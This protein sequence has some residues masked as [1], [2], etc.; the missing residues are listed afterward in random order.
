MFYVNC[1]VNNAS[2]VFINGCSFVRFKTI[3]LLSGA[4][5]TVEKEREGVYTQKYEILIANR[6]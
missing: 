6:K 2:N 5:G 3:N 1:N 4:H